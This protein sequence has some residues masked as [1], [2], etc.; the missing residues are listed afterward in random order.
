M[1]YVGPY[2]PKVWTSS[3]PTTVKLN[4]IHLNHRLREEDE[5]KCKIFETK[6]KNPPKKS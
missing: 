3:P 2:R 6:P 5:R 4:H 1:H